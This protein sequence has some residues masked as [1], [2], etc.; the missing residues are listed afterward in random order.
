MTVDWKLEIT[1]PE[2]TAL[3]DKLATSTSAMNEI[4]G[5]VQP[6]ESNQIYACGYRWDNPLLEKSRTAS[7]FQMDDEG[8]VTVLYAFGDR[9]SGTQHDVCRAVAYDDANQEILFALEATSPS[10]RP[11]YDDYAQY[12]AANTDVTIIRMKSGGK[13]AGAYNINFYDASISIGI[14]A[15]ALFTKDGE[16]IF[17]TQSWG[18]YTK[19]QNKTYN[20]TA[21]QLDTNVFRYSPDSSECFYQASMNAA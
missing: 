1:N 9:V 18:Y 12:S 5:Y 11:E 20:A 21:V 13:L 4:Y 6:P 15:N 7:M 17:G 16:Y 3:A 19:Y 10:L 2:V 8:D 14:G